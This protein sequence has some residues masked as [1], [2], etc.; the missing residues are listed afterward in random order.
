MRYP[1]VEGQGN[2]GSIDGD[3][4][5]AM[6][7]TEVRMAKITDQMLNDI[8]K[9]TVSYSPNYDGSEDIPDVLPT[10]IPN[11]LVNGSSGIAVGIATNIPPHNITEVLNGCINLLTIR[12]SIDELIKDIS[13][14][15]FLPWR[16]Y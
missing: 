12:V 13:G 9:E 1:I 7:Y 2:F 16:N 8:E 3:P 15:D 14:P 4:P 5:A 11:L 10:K 6:R